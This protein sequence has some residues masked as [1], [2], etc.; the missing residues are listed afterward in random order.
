MHELI[1]FYHKTISKWFKLG[2]KLISFT[3][4]RGGG[5]ATNVDGRN[6]KLSDCGAYVVF[7]KYDNS[8][9]WVAFIFL[10]YFFVTLH[11]QEHMST[12]FWATF[13]FWIIFI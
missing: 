3:G 13:T 1:F 5:E 6:N 4:N 2:E 11:S 10:L 7:E 12:H 8:V 9:L